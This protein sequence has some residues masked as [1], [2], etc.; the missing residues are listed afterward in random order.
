MEEIKAK[1]M[2]VAKIINQEI[3]LLDGCRKLVR[4]YATG[5]VRSHLYST[6][7][8]HKSSIPKGN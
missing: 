1:I 8:L 4:T 2:E 7:I 5:T 3:D 6:Q